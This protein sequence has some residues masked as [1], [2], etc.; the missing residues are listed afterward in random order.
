MPTFLTLSWEKNHIYLWYTGFQRLRRWKDVL[1]AGLS[2]K[3]G[4]LAM[5]ENWLK[6]GHTFLGT[7]NR[8][9]YNEDSDLFRSIT[10]GS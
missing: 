7:I 8:G 1:I 4:T 5:M 2:W 6:G 9:V 10:R 3:Y